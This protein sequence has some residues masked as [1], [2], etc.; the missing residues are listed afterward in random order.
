MTADRKE[1]VEHIAKVA[2][3]KFPPP[4]ADTSMPADMAWEEVFYLLECL[5][6]VDR[7]DTGVMC[8]FEAHLGMYRDGLI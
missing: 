6:Y 7:E 2:V 5:G 3:R 4:L 1:R 8:E